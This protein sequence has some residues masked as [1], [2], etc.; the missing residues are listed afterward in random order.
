MCIYGSI[1][2]RN[3]YIYIYT[4]VNRDLNKKDQ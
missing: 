2:L 4:Y 3:I 1:E